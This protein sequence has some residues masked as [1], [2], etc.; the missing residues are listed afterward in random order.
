VGDQLQALADDPVADDPVFQNSLEQLELEAVI[1]D[2]DEFTEHI[3]AYNF[4]H[5]KKWAT[6]PI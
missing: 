5:R 1:A 2:V 4:F 6:W 3:A